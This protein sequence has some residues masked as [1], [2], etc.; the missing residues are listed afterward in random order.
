M[1]G[2][3]QVREGLLEI[4]IAVHNL[5]DLGKNMVIGWTADDGEIRVA[6]ASCS[7]MLGHA[8][9]NPRLLHG[10]RLMDRRTFARACK[11]VQARVLRLPVPFKIGTNTLSGDVLPEAIDSI[12]RRYSIVR[13]PHRAVMLFEIADFATA[14]PVEQV[15]QFV[16]L[17]HSISTASEILGNAGLPVELARSTAGDGA[18]YLWNR[19][20]GL[21]G[22]LRAYA[23]FLLILAANEVAHRMIVDS[24]GIVPRLRS[25]LTVGSH[26]SYHQVEGNKPR[27]FEYATGQVSI[28]LARMLS[29]ALPGQVLLGHFERPGESEN[30][31]AMDAVLF[32]ARAEA[33]LA[34][35]NGA[36]IEE[37]AIDE[38]RSLVTGGTVGGQRHDIL[39]YAVADKHGFQ[40]E[41][42]N[43]RA[44]LA[45]PGG[46]AIDIGLRTADVAAFEATASAYAMPF[47]KPGKTRAPEAVGA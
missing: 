20:E 9:E 19:N 41:A 28:T 46:T 2:L 36:A 11:T 25:G 43:L 17:E 8:T 26:Y 13:T 27:T 32:V 18:L 3:S 6:F 45:G 39:K 33:L 42:F 7:R 5:W 21:Q 15:A 47:A 29:K 30:S 12:V 22:D 38:L 40:H 14:S 24:R 10:P 23:A 1:T 34:R 16:S 4:D 44:K 37:Y 31:S 35:L